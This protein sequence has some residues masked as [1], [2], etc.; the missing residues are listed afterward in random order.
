MSK[1]SE[2]ELDIDEQGHAKNTQKAAVRAKWLSNPIT[3]P[4]YFEH[5][6]DYV[7][8]KIEDGAK[9]ADKVQSTLTKMK[10]ADADADRETAKGCS[11]FVRAKTLQV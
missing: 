6:F 8:T 5:L 7:M 1:Y 4:Q 10:E 2:P 11:H 3:Q 9:K